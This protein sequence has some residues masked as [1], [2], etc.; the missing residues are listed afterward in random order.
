VRAYER[1]NDCKACG[2]TGRV[3]RPRESWEPP[4]IGDDSQLCRECYGLPAA[5]PVAAP[6]RGEGR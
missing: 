6:T 3:P 4:F 2:G 5:S 1:V